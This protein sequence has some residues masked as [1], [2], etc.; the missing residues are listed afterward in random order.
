MASLRLAAFTVI[1]AAPWFFLRKAV[2]LPIVFDVVLLI[3]LLACAIRLK[4]EIVRSRWILIALAIAFALVWLGYGVRDGNQVRYYGLFAIDFGPLVSVVAT[5]RAS[6]M[7]PLNIVAGSGP[8]NYHWL[9]FTLPAMFADFMPASTAL[10]IANFL[11]AVLLVLTLSSIV[12]DQRVVAIVIFAPLTL[13]Y[14]QVIA[15][16]LGIPP[17]TRN[18]LVLSPLNSMIVFGNNTFAL[19][20][21]LLAIAQLEKW[22][23]E[24]RIADLISGSIFLAAIIG[25]SVTLMIPLAITLMVW[26]LLGRVRR[27]LIAIVVAAVAG[28]I[29]IAIFFAIGILGHDASRHIAFAFDRG[30]FLLIAIVGM[31]PLW[32]LLVL[33]LLEGRTPRP[34]GAARAALM[35]GWADEGVRP[36]MLRI[37]HVLIASCLFVPT[38][39]YIAGSATGQFDMS[40][41]IATLMVI[42]FAP[43]IEWPPLYGLV[44]VLLGL[45][46]TAAYV[47]QFPYYRFT[48]A[49]SHNVAI[50]ADYHDA[51][52]WIRDHTPIDAVVEDPA[53]VPVWQV[54]FPTMIGERRVSMPTTYTRLYVIGT[55]RP[56]RSEA[57]I[58]VAHNDVS[59]PHWQL[60]HRSGEWTV[61]A[62]R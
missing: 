6:P 59:D 20:L 34:P 52:V 49:T 15:P 32:T 51:L 43:L 17:L 41:K 24:G 36:S 28:A 29:A 13:Y 7:L 3:A 56:A 23:A 58:L 12:R 48:H 55:Q 62:R 40:M 1:A 47:A 4:N 25:Y 54:V 11:I 53:S 39:L 35:R 50:A 21:A 26:T 22:N 37:H 2:G 18:H 27:P 45:G 31:L 5:L 60:V 33:T 44:V 14:F 19:V 8:L 30:A 38:F 61:C 10:L 9:Y 46:Q 16:R 42:A 57:T